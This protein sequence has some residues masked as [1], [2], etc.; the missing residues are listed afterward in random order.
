MQAQQSRR[1]S[2][3]EHSCAWFENDVE[4]E[5][6]EY[7]WNEKATLKR[8]LMLIMT[9]FLVEVFNFLSLSMVRSL[10]EL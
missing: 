9:A 8:C 6:K 3:V 4:R 1:L 10:G 7:L 5:E 2:G